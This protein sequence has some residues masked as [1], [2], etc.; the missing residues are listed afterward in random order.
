MEQF[1]HPPL[2]TLM[3][4]LLLLGALA[5]IFLSTPRASPPGAF[6]RMVR[7]PVY[8]YLG[9]TE[10]FKSLPYSGLSLLLYTLS[11]EI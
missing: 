11:L 7:D 9:Q 3:P 8:S 6:Q 1:L 2:L 5:R 4:R 10:P